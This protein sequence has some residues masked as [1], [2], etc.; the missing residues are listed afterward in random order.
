[1]RVKRH[2]DPLL[3]VLRATGNGRRGERDALLDEVV[4]AIPAAPIG[5]AMLSRAGAWQLGEHNPENGA[6]ILNTPLLTTAV[7][8]HELMHRIRPGW[9]EFAIEAARLELLSRMDD[10]LIAAVHRQLERAIRA[11]L[12]RRRAR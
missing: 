8:L 9:D 11:G 10:D 7:A 2:S 6:I 12:P 3:S 1:M 5:E 4:A